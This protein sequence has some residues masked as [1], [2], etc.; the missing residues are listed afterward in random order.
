[1]STGQLVLEG[2]L[3]LIGIVGIW[4]TGDKNNYG[5]LLS[6][7][8]QILWIVYAAVTAQYFFIVVCVAYIIVYIKAFTKWRKDERN[9]DDWTAGIG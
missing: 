1:M 8:Y 5:W 6:I 7:L 3:S 9:T 4:L 2:V